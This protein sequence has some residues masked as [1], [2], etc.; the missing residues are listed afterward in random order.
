MTLGISGSLAGALLLPGAPAQ[1]APQLA[2]IT[3]DGVTGVAQYTM[4]VVAQQG[5]FFARYGVPVTVNLTSITA[6]GADLA[7]GK[8]DL[9]YISPSSAISLAQNGVSTQIVYGIAGQQ[10]FYLIAAPN[11]T[12]SQLKSMSNCAIGTLAAGTSTYGQAA[13]YVDGLHLHCAIR[14]LGSAALVAAAIASGQIQ[15]GVVDYATS[16]TAQSAGTAHIIVDPF[17]TKLGKQYAL[18]SFLA[19]VI[20][21]LKDDLQQKRASV[22]AALHAIH[23]A[24]QLVARQPSEVTATIGKTNPGY[25]A[26]TTA[27][28]S[29]AIDAFKPSIC[30]TW[31]ESND[32]KAKWKATL[33]VYSKYFG[34]TN[35]V[36]NSSALS[37]KNI[38]DMSYL[39]AAAKSKQAA[40]DNENVKDAQCSFKG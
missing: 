30:S 26:Q 15:A 2:P 19:G 34:L 13:K 24:S 11:I 35:F 18:P 29:S 21:G 27:A 9:W 40:D 7:S 31:S 16:L 4:L 37:Y 6:G 25:A 33:Q 32:T 8:A 36:P 5:G 23:D 28:L 38:V 3:I 39:N 1:A 20:I 10:P 12:L 17:T 22:V 14:S